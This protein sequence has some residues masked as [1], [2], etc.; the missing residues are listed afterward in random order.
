MALT[1][2]RD[3][4]IE[5][6]RVS[7][8]IDLIEVP[9]ANEITIGLSQFN[10]LIDS[11]DLDSLWPYT[12]KLHK[13]NFVSGQKNY[14]IGLAVGDDIQIRRPD[15]INNFGFIIGGN[16]FRPLNRVG[17]VDYQNSYKTENLSTLPEAYAYYPDF[18][19]SR[20]EVFPT[21]NSNYEYTLQYSVKLK[22]YTLNENLELPSGYASYLTWGLAEV[23]CDMQGSNNVLVK[24]R[25]IKYLEAIRKMNVEPITMGYGNLPMGGGLTWDVLADGYK[26]SY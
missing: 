20:I 17:M 8:L 14:T 15:T 26:D 13:G 11:L 19:S 5:A 10:Q 3:L 6:Y 9:E 7:G 2:A 16:T 4:I 24:T 25:A 22:D 23:L 1:T 12:K 21:P 18:P